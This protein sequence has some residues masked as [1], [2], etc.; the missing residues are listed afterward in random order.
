MVKTVFAQR[1]KQLGKLL[2]NN[3]GKEKA[4]PALEALNI[5]TETRPDKLS[6]DQYAQLTR[7][8][9]DLP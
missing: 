5:P 2:S 1:R 7:L 9:F 8:L 4:L 3:Y 6:V